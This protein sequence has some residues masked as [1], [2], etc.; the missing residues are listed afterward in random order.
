MKLPD[1]PLEQP[2]PPEGYGEAE[3]A[4]HRSIYAGMEMG[5]AVGQAGAAAQELGTEVYMGA[6]TRKMAEQ[7]SKLNALKQATLNDLNK[8]TEISTTE[9]EARYG[10]RDKIPKDVID[11]IPGG[12]DNKYTDKGVEQVVPRSDI[13]IHAIKD[14]LFRDTIEK[15][16]DNL[17]KEIPSPGWGAGFARSA[18]NDLRQEQEHIAA[19]GVHEEMAYQQ[20]KFK[21]MIAEDMNAGNFDMAQLHLDLG[22]R[23]IHPVDQEKIQHQIKVGAAQYPVAEIKAGEDTVAMQ[24]MIEGIQAHGENGGKFSVK[25]E[26]GSTREVDTAM[27]TEKERAAAVIGLT[28][29]IHTV[30]N[31]RKAEKAQNA[32]ALMD[33]SW[34]VVNRAWENKDVRAL[35]NITDTM[36]KAG[37][38]VENLPQHKLDELERE[39]ATKVD[40]LTK[41]HKDPA[42]KQDT[43]IAKQQLSTALDDV[44]RTGTTNAINPDTGK[45]F[46]FAP[47]KD[48]NR[49]DMAGYLSTHN[50]PYT[51]PQLKAYNDAVDGKVLPDKTYRDAVTD[52]AR[53]IAPDLEQLANMPGYARAGEKAASL[54]TLKEGLDISL[55]EERAKHGGHLSQ[56]QLRRWGEAQTAG[57]LER[58]MYKPSLF[59]NTNPDTVN[60]GGVPRDIRIAVAKAHADLGLPNNITDQAAWVQEWVKPYAEEISSQFIDKF[61]RPPTMTEKLHISKMVQSLHEGGSKATRASK[62]VEEAL[63]LAMQSSA[64]K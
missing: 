43:S 17:A 48:G 61:K 13:P 40:R 18:H 31:G 34:G 5:R 29:R 37:I 56:D 42:V 2:R 58:M 35:M 39:A 44:A 1:L 62:L 27:L 24:S 59:G 15:N 9:L 19:Q 52:V 46:D 45:P 36:R 10:G 25:Q 14:K 20:Q 11:A 3:Y 4:Y 16:I 53:R 57:E 49:F 50:I 22:S 54:A 28:R 32:E 30:E 8:Q 63:P 47:D 60:V 51:Y 64:R 55:Q 41:T 7:H 23:Y 38:D 21:E 12:L 26:D 33:S 6:V